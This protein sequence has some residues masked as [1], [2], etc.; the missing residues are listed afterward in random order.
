MKEKEL[1][2]IE[3]RPVITYR[4]K[5]FANVQS[6]KID[7]LMGWPGM[8]KETAEALVESADNAAAILLWQP[9]EKLPKP[10]GGAGIT[11]QQIADAC[12]DTGVPYKTAKNRVRHQGWSLG[13][14]TTT[15]VGKRTKKAAV[16]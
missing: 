9:D 14:A 15:P 10:V 1:F 2:A 16:E 4:G 13:R 12:R 8:T 7:A 3:N 6:A 11:D 5:E